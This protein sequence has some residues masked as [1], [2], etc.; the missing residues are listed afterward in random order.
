MFE[1]FVFLK[2]RDIAV[3]VQGDLDK[4]LGFIDGLEGEKLLVS[5][6]APEG[7]LKE[8]GEVIPLEDEKTLDPEEIE[9]RSYSTIEKLLPEGLGKME[10]KV[11]ERMVHASG[12]PMVARMIR[13]SKGAI[14]K[15]LDA[16]KSGEKIITDTRMVAS[17]ISRKLLEKVECEL[18]CAL[19]LMDESGGETRSYRAFRNL[20]DILNGSIVAIGNAPTALMACLEM[21]DEGVIPS[22]VIGT[23]VGFVQAK[24]LKELLARSSV[25]HIT[26]FGTRGGSSI[27]A[28]AVNALLSLI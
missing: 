26:L 20:G 23:P 6:A 18:V 22:I 27:A 16:L 8:K 15:G 9:R 25:P 2:D 24:E 14:E 7:A 28:A 13:I 1:V 4:V 11:V 12:D 3:S 5:T 17:G 21:V 19:D 10:R